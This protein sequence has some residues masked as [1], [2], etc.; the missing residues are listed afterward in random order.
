M[1]WLARQS[2]EDVHKTL[3]PLKWE[4]AM[5]QKYFSL[6]AKKKKKNGVS[7]A[8]RNETFY[9]GWPKEYISSHFTNASNLL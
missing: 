7:R 6:L 3:T 8:M 4:E 1:F 2:L 9:E 5:N